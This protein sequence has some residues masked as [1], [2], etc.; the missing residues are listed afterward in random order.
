MSARPLADLLL[1]PGQAGAYYL[2]ASDLE[3]L[4]DAAAELG[5]CCAHVS[6]ADCRDKQEL[7]QR[8][9]TVLEFPEGFGF[10][11][12]A[13]AD[14]LG[15]LSWL[16]AEGYVLGLQHSQQFRREHPEDYDTLVSVLEEA[17]DGWRDQAVPFWAFITVPDD[18]F[19][20]IDA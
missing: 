8:F 20:A 17:A 9:A 7:L 6:L 15:D 3:P 4:Q 11:W 19:A 18:D 13:L 16:A 2:T 12:D 1:Q 10:N 14:S 5:M